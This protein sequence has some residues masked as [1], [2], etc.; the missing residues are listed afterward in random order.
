M[1]QLLFSSPIIAG[2]VGM[3]F[4]RIVPDLVGVYFC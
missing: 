2:L 1:V 4:V 3:V